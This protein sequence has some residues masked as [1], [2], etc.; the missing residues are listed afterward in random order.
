MS[1]RHAFVYSFSFVGATMRM[2]HLK[3]NLRAY[4]FVLPWLIMLVG[5]TAYPTL[6]AFYY[7]MTR[8]TIVKP[9]QWVGFENYT[10]MFTNDPL[11]WASV[12]NTLY[13][14]AI[15]VPLSLL[16]GLL[17]AILLNQNTRGVGVYRTLFYLPALVPTVAAGLIWALLLA[18][19]GGLVNQLL[20]VVGIAP[21]NWMSS[22][23][24]AKPGLILTAVWIGSGSLTLI[25]L[26][27]LKDVPRM[28]IEAALI[29]G[30]NTWQRYRFVI[31]PML[32]PTIFFNLITSLIGSFQV[33][34]QALAVAGISGTVGPSNSLL[35]YVIHIYRNAFS[36]FSMGYASALAVVL[37]LVLVVFT[38]LVV[39]SSSFWVYYEGGSPK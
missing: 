11:F 37:F 23:M 15:S 12:W 6:G 31:L 14:T 5:L 3:D 32:T 38:L 33:F 30:A 9:P 13:Y 1:A 34:G 2:R 35:M 39:R 28:L 19:R 24:W 20:G 8:Y 17:L 7:A 4:L 29:D 27:G 16:V 18:P 36:Y 26:A 21:L 10:R 22:A 25:F